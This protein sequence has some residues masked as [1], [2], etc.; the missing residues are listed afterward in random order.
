M[1]K[2]TFIFKNP[3]AGAAV[4]EI[5]YTAGDPSNM[6]GW[7]LPKY[8]Y[9]ITKPITMDIPETCAVAFY[10]AAYNGQQ[11]V[12]GVGYGPTNFVNGATYIWDG[13]AE[14]L[15]KQGSDVP[16]PAPAP[17]PSGI[18]SAL[19]YIIAGSVG[20]LGLVMVTKKKSPGG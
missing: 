2:V 5:A 8:A 14:T 4:W 12:S 10:A 18:S 6:A 9:A 20:V 15:T 13:V 7:T 16:A 19:P 11:N 3:P 1:V 17:A